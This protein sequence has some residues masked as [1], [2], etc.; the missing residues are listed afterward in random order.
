[1]VHTSKTSRRPPW[2]W[3][4]GPQLANWSNFLRRERAVGEVGVSG[5]MP[6]AVL[7]VNSGRSPRVAT[8]SAG[9]GEAWE[10]KKALAR[11]R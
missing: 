5:G 3:K 9:T 4:E 2:A 11:R 10:S 7:Q 1:M 6:E 8:R